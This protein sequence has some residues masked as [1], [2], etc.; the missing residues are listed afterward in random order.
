MD[1]ASGRDPAQLDVDDDDD[2][3]ER[4]LLGEGTEASSAL[5]V[6]VSLALICQNKFRRFLM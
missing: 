2:D 5:G 4:G 3:V 6:A 1:G